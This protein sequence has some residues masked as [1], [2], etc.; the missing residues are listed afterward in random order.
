MLPLTTTK[1]KRK[2][3]TH[4]LNKELLYAMEAHAKGW[5][6]QKY[7]AMLGSM[8]AFENDVAAIAE[9]EDVQQFLSSIVNTNVDCKDPEVIHVAIDWLHLLVQKRCQENNNQDLLTFLQ[10]YDLRKLLTLWRDAA[11]FSSNVPSA[12][13]VWSKVKQMH[14]FLSNSCVVNDLILDVAIIQSRSTQSAPYEIQ[15]LWQE[16]AYS[17]T[18]D[19]YHVLLR[20]WSH[21]QLPEA[22]QQMNQ[23]LD[24]MRHSSDTSIQPTI[25]SYNI[26]LENAAIT[27]D[28]D[29]IEQVRKITRDSGL[30]PTLQTFELATRGYARAG[31]PDL[32][33]YIMEHIFV[34]A[35]AMFENL[36]MSDNENNDHDDDKNRLVEQQKHQVIRCVERSTMAMLLSY[37][38]IVHWSSD[39]REQ[40][41]QLSERL[42]RRELNQRYG[43][44]DPQSH[45]KEKR[46]R[47]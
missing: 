43:L 10:N 38:R 22:K 24:E 19:M 6:V 11:Q 1:K 28:I 26:L 41:T 42:L 39:M 4:Y 44:V 29:T 33:E 37:G 31:R 9:L 34:N 14:S 5:N 30:A 7:R 21:S 23:I 46:E 25:E 15:P 45:G 17:L 20:C 32:A 47:E 18:R 13:D 36:T 2:K 8:S 40:A 35:S 12:H 3:Q 27:G 16:M